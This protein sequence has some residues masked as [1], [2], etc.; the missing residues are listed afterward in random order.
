MGLENNFS[1]YGLDQTFSEANLMRTSLMLMCITSQFL[2]IHN[3]RGWTSWRRIPPSCLG[4]WRTTWCWAW[5][6]PETWRT[7]WWGPALPGPSWGPMSTNLRTETGKMSRWANLT[8]TETTNCYC[9]WR[10]DHHNKRGQHAEERHLHQDWR[11]PGPCGRQ[12]PLPTHCGRRRRDSQGHKEIFLKVWG[13]LV[14]SAGLQGWSDL[15]GTDWLTE[16]LSCYMQQNIFLVK[17]N[18]F[19]NQLGDWGPTY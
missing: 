15:G 16:Y 17:R 10:P 6:G 8:C 3:F 9:Y 13:D 2:F 19:L 5:S 7:T 4:S 14:F 18:V 1:I 11:G 12:S